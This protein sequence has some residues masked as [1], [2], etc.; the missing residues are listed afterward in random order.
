MKPNSRTLPKTQ[1]A[2]QLVGQGLL[3]LNDAKAVSRPGPHQIL[4]RVEATALCFS[5]LK[6][7]KQFSEHAR[8][9]EI[10]HGIAREVLSEIPSYVPGDKPTVP[11]HETVCRIVE[12]GEKVR[13]HSPGERYLVQAD[14]RSLSTKGSKAAFGY[15]F[16]G[17]LQEYVLMDERVVFDPE[18]NQRY[19]LPVDEHLSA[20]AVC[21]V[22]PWACVEDSY[23]TA[24]RR[25]VLAGGKLLVVADAGREI[26]GV[27]ESF[28]PAGTSRPD[29]TRG[30]GGKPA[31]MTAVCREGGQLRTLKSLG[32]SVVEKRSVDDLPNE[33]F[34]DILYFGANADTLEIL[35]DKLG[36]GGIINVVTGGRKIGRPVSV[37]IGRIHYSLCRWIGTVGRAASDSYRTIPEN[38]GIRPG[39]K[40]IVVG[41]GGPMGQMHVIRDI[42]SGTPGISIV[43]ADLDSAR[44]DRLHEKV[45]ALAWAQGVAVRARKEPGEL[46]SYSVVSAPVPSLVAEAVSNCLPGGLI[47]LFAGMPVGIKQALDMDAYIAQRC[48]MFGTSGSVIRDMEIVLDKVHSGRLDTSRSVDAV[49]GMAGG[50]D[51]IAAIENRTLTGKIVV[52]PS[53][54]GLGLVPLSELERRLPSV[55]AKLDAGQWCKAAEEELLATAAS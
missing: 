52:Y 9:G 22:E 29:G 7:V 37:G 8:K 47:N 27:A 25:S 33:T 35:N 46:F 49:S 13:H 14:Y 12:V 10:V 54:Y 44:L 15:N 41:A 19:L 34:D 24:E 11:G 45:Q 4:A 17:G 18:T 5:D 3:R 23:V 2:L 55:A 1:H 30:P 31:E 53:C 50:L 40:I 20:A 51:G 38:G 28:A 36:A 43:I 21:L 39:E 6:L 16:E 42:C 48:Y 32:A 26:M